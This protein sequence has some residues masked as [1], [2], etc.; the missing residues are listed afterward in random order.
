MIDAQSSAKAESDTTIDMMM[1]AA[2]LHGPATLNQEVA[3]L[4]LLLCAAA[5]LLAVTGCCGCC[6]RMGDASQYEPYLT[7]ARDQSQ[8]SRE[9]WAEES[10]GLLA[11][12]ID[13]TIDHWSGGPAKSQLTRDQEGE[14]VGADE[15]VAALDPANASPPQ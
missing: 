4:V 13:S 6:H 12:R 9:I 1:G 2:P 14:A 15:K 10:R 11:A 3:L 7:M 5:W 8:H